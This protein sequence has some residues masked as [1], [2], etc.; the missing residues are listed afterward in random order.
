MTDTGVALVASE[1][2][3]LSKSPTS[4]LA[5]AALAAQN[6]AGLERADFIVVAVTPGEL[7]DVVDNVRRVVAAS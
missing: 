2:L 5:A 4:E 3:N 6:A 7:G 1:T